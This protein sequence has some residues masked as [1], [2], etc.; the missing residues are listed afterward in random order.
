MLS[1]RTE[2]SA[3]G[4][5]ITDDGGIR[6]PPFPPQLPHLLVPGGT[7]VIAGWESLTETLYG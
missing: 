1:V 4:G 3:H 7:R 2:Y 6:Q 5:Q